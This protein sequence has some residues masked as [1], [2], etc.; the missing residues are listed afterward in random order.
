MSRATLFAC[1]AWI[2]SHAGAQEIE[3]FAGTRRL[4]SVKLPGARATPRAE[5]PNQPQAAPNPPV[6]AVAAPI[7]PVDFRAPA[8]PFMLPS[9]RPAKLVESLA[10]PAP[11]AAGG[12]GEKPR[13]EKAVALEE[14]AP[15]ARHPANPL[16]GFDNPKDVWEWIVVLGHDMQSV[17]LGLGSAATML[18][19]VAILRPR[20]MNPAPVV[21]VT[22]PP[23]QAPVYAWGPP[24]APRKRRKK[25]KGGPS[26]QVESGPREPN[27]TLG[28]SF[29]EEKAQR[30]AQ[31][32]QAEEALLLG[33]VDANV[34][35]RGAIES[36]QE[37]AAAA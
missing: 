20:G 8:E 35:L 14:K 5:A 23:G 32:S 27:F 26:E 24:A 6:I 33:L 17:S 4:E 16:P 22:M 37:A 18:A 11:A 36:R 19:L 34:A 21:N 3:Q 1:L 30:E 31:A 2:C 25:R 10:L 7:K 12:D 28:P 29:E 9:L 13:A 15:E